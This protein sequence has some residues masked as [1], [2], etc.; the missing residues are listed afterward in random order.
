MEVN[1][2]TVLWENEEG[3]LYLPLIPGKQIVYEFDLHTPLSWIEHIDFNVDTLEFH[4]EDFS[5]Q[6]CT[7]VDEKGQGENRERTVCSNGSKGT[8]IVLDIESC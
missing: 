8:K 5:I 7:F 6:K 2:Q 1:V 4:N 3:S